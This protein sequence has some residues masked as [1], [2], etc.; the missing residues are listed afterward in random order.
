MTNILQL[1]FIILAAA[2]A[3]VLVAAGLDLPA[4]LEDPGAG[5]TDLRTSAAIGI[6]LHGW[7]IC[8]PLATRV[9]WLRKLVLAL[10]IPGCIAAVALAAGG[11]LV[12][13]FLTNPRGLFLFVP[14]LGYVV[15]YRLARIK[16]RDSQA[17]IRMES[18]A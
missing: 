4:A 18:D 10:S 11:V 16:A 7:I 2:L 13:F 12:V 9:E 6:I 8:V 5:E 17:N 15:S 3:A 14:V 1:T